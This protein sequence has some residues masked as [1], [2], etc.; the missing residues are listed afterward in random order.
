MLV[1]W[2]WEGKVVSGTCLGYVEVCHGLMWFFRFGKNALSCSCSVDLWVVGVK[3][4]VSGV[5][6]QMRLIFSIF[7]FS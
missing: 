7:D 1:G 6:F 4:D 5:I 2:C 3:W